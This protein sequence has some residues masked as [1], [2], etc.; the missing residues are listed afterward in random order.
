MSR[1]TGWSVVLVL[2]LGLLGACGGPNA[3]NGDG[4]EDEPEEPSIPVEV[5][6]A[7]LGLM[8]TEPIS[9]G[10]LITVTVFESTGA[11]DS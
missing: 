5:A 2:S 6:A 7:E 4:S 3:D 1:L 10:V 9:G 8:D 11:P